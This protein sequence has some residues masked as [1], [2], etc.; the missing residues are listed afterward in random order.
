MVI[1]SCLYLAVVYLVFFKWKL[2]PFNKITGGIVVVLGVMILTV[3]LVGLQT[4]VRI[5]NERLAQ[6]VNLH[7]ALGGSF[8]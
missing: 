6:R 2:L 5:K 4:L 1:V 8:E 3:F 7:L